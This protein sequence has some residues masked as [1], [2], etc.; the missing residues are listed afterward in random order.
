MSKIQVESNSQPALSASE[1][2]WCCDQYVKDTIWK[3]FTTIYLQNKITFLLW[4]ICQRYNLKAIHNILTFKIFKI[5][6]V[7]NMS[8]IQFESNSQHTD[9][10]KYEELCCDQYVKDTIWKQFTT[11]CINSH[12]RPS[13]WPICQ[14]YNLK[15]IH[16]LEMT[17]KM[18]HS[19]V[20]N[21]SKIQFESN[22]Q[23]G[24]MQW[25]CSKC[26]DQYVKDTIWKQFTTWRLLVG[27]SLLLWPICQRYNLKA[28][29][30]SKL[31]HWGKHPVVTNMSKIQ[32]ESN[33]QPITS[34]Q[35][36]GAR[37]DQYVKDTIWKQ[38]TTPTHKMYSSR[39][40]WPIC[41]RYNLKAIHNSRL[42]MK[43]KSLV[44]TNM[45]KIQFESNSQRS[46]NERD[47]SDGC[48]QYVKDT[49]WKQFTTLVSF[50]A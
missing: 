19:V 4:P 5:I 16:N 2:T 30:N 46:A 32:F 40:L 22:S 17:Q 33:S 48:D 21:M 3:Q 20:T 34:R 10:T 29:H 23:P 31:I 47:E 26:C 11:P 36:A 37:C 39:R 50:R 35:I 7:T 1:T 38:F 49:I 9:M 6:V 14:R 41:Q 25:N 12:T 15:A 27:H 13:L 45:S 28:I 43:L 44:V 8:K 24:A 42:P 18:Q